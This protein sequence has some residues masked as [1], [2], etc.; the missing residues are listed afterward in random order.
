MWK[1]C[2][3]QAAVQTFKCQQ[4]T[5]SFLMIIIYLHYNDQFR[6]AGDCT[7]NSLSYQFI[8]FADYFPAE[9]VGIITS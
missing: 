5:L 7:A 6:D 2:I 9:L 8:I 3:F 1:K 4:L